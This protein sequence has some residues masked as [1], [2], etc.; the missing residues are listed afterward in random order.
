M[1]G[2]TAVSAVA[3]GLGTGA[4]TARPPAGTPS[5]GKKLRLIYVATNPANTPIGAI[6]SNAFDAAG[7]ELGVEVVYRSTPTSATSAT[8]LKPLI[9]NAVASKPDGLVITDTLPSALNPTIKA[10]V[11]SG[12]PVVLAQTGA[13]EATATGALTFVGNDETAAGMLGGKLLGEAGAKHALMV[14]VPP[15]IPIAEDRNNGFERG[16]PGKV[17]FLQVPLSN[18]V[19]ATKNAIL[20][21]LQKDPTIDGVFNVGVLMSPAMLAAQSQLGARAAEIRWSALD[22]DPQ[23]LGAIKDGKLVFALDQQP[24][25]QGYLPVL[26]IKQYLT[27]GLKPAL[28]QIPTGP[29]AVTAANVDQV[30]AL[31]EKKLR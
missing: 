1:L 28:A 23:V 8:Q 16:F 7:K 13:G 4:C 29:S 31:S 30:L 2:G 21:S 20:A 14:T 5:P 3:L 15:G 25:L 18:D 17:T 19:T 22:I 11:D 9:E 10:A 24:Y 12:I 26:F 27:L 6:I